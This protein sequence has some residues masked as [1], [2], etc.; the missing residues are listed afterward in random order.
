MAFYYPKHIRRL[1]RDGVEADAVILDFTEVRTHEGR[2][3][4]VPVVRWIDADGTERRADE[5]LNALPGDPRLRGDGVRLLVG[6]TGRGD[7][8]VLGEPGPEAAAI[9]KK[10]MRGE[11]GLREMFAK[12]GVTGTVEAEVVELVPEQG[13]TRVR[14]RGA[15]VDAVVGP[16]I[17]APDPRRVG[18]RV[19]LILDAGGN[20]VRE[21]FGPHM[22]PGAREAMAREPGLL[23]KMW[24]SEFNPF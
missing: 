24:D 13:G 17:A 10:T 3:G 22:E 2:E 11:V 4:R 15:G 5:Q 8:M 12:P 9:A 20:I 16:V 19:D 14:V 21:P 18:D 1:A 7:V 6:Q 23:R